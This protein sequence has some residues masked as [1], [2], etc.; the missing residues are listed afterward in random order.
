MRR[1]VMA[2]LATMLGSG[3]LIGLKS[4]PDRDPG[5]AGRRGTRR[6]GAGGAA[7]ARLDRDDA[8]RGP[9][10]NRVRRRRPSAGSG[11]GP[12]GGSTA[13][14]TK[15][16]TA[17]AGSRTLTG[18]AVAASGFGSMQVR[19]VGDRHPHRQHQHGPPVQPAGEDSQRA[20]APG[21][22]GPGRTE[23]VVQDQVSGATYSCEAWKQSLQNA[24]G[25]L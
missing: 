4:R 11:D 9:G 7:V 3:L 19:I 20:D 12:R 1:V 21:P 18:T 14:T 22:V 25:Q 15:P 10:R 13:P 17:P 2:L 23:R 5:R 24:I 8:S 16:S 6:A